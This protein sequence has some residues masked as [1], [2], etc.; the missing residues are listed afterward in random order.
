MRVTPRRS[1]RTTRANVAVGVYGHTNMI[2]CCCSLRPRSV[3]LSA[4]PLRRQASIRCRSIQ[5]LRHHVTTSHSGVSCVRKG[6]VV[7]RRLLYGASTVMLLRYRHVQRDNGE[8]TRVRRS[9]TRHS[10]YVMPHTTSTTF[11]ELHATM[12]TAQRKMLRVMPQNKCCAK[13]QCTQATNND[14]T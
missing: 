2:R 4:T 3:R 7:T 1:C 10:H 11:G 12:S 14:N 5:R 8:N 13:Q 9:G 6:R